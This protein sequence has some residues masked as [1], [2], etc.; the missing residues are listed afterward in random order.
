V[1]LTRSDGLFVNREVVVQGYAQLLSI[2]PNTARRD[3]LLRAAREAEA[4]GAGL[5]SAC[6]G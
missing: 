5:W 3:D 4:S 1:Y 6:A 2:E